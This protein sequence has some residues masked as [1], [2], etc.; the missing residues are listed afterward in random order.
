[1]R[2]KQWFETVGM[3]SVNARSN[4]DVPF[5]ADGKN[6]ILRFSLLPTHMVF[7]YSPYAGGKVAEVVWFPA[8]KATIPNDQRYERTGTNS[9]GSVRQILS[10]LPP[11]IERW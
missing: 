7:P 11:L 1:M 5:Q 4:Q 8:E 6:Y 10:I 9:L 2:F 3:P